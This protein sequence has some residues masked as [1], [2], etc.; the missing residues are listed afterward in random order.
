MKRKSNI[1]TIVKKELAR[2]FGD[3]RMVASIFLPGILIY[4]VYSLMGDAMMSGFGVDEDTTYTLQVEQMPAS[5][6]G[7]L[8]AGE[9]PFE[10]VE[11]ED[12]MSAVEAQELDLYVVFPESFEDDIL[13]SQKEKEYLKWHQFIII[14]LN[15]V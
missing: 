2:F 6:Q 15:V 8:D 9:L 5:I 13:K 4:L 3:R 10:I 14:L 11:T 12:P 1:L 7:M